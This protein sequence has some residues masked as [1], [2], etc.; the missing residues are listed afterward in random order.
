MMV[1]TRMRSQERNCMKN[2]YTANSKIQ[3]S[4]FSLKMHEVCRQCK[5]KTQINMLWNK[6]TS[7]S[8]LHSL[9]RFILWSWGG[10]WIYVKLCF[11]SHIYVCTYLFTYTHVSIIYME[12][13]T[14][15]GLWLIGF[16]S[17]FSDHE[18]Y[19]LSLLVNQD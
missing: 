6:G 13:E 7:F 8:M 2:N 1:N 19:F 4:A 9:K 14:G 17:L 5:L 16:F 15:L 3:A 18:K 12:K 11:T 10:D